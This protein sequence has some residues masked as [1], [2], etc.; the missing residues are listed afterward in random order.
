[1][2]EASKI[3]KKAEEQRVVERRRRN[4]R[5]KRPV[6]A[7]TVP[8]KKMTKE[9]MRIGRMLFPVA[10]HNRPGTRAECANVERPCPFVSCKYN[11]YL[12]VNPNTGSVKMNFPDIEVWEM[13]DS[14]ALDVAERGGVTLEEVG[15][16]MN[17]TRERIRQLE[18]SGLSKLAGEGVEDEE[19]WC[20]LA[21]FA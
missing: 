21:E 14:C 10:D 4:T 13:K 15:E 16:I 9:Q 17:L 1:M 2:S 20:D 11:L 19:D 3:E 18:M 6:R 5:R 8:V 7:R 12:D